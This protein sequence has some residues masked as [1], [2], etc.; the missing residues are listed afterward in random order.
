MRSDRSAALGCTQEETV[1]GDNW[2]VYNS[3]GH[4]Q[5]LVYNQLDYPHNNAWTRLLDQTCG[6]LDTAGYIRRLRISI[7]YRVCFIGC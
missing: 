7:P 2:E 6:S 4:L 5:S 1:Y 3:I